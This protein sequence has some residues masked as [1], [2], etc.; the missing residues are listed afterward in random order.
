MMGHCL[1]GVRTEFG[2][3]KDGIW[4]DGELVDEM[5][6]L[7]DNGIE[8][9]IETLEVTHRWPGTGIFMWKVQGTYREINRS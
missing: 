8:P 1:L 6:K 5:M 4:T 3:A 9:H 2:G 7:Q